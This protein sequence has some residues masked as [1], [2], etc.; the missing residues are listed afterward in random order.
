[1][2]KLPEVCPKCG[3]RIAAYT[4]E[5]HNGTTEVGYKCIQQC[6]WKVTF[7]DLQNDNERLRTALR[8]VQWKTMSAGQGCSAYPTCVGCGVVSYGVL[9]NQKH[10]SDCTIENALQKGG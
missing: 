8:E 5:S 2:S 3:G 4:R 6:D 10:E 7:A 1:M 9:L